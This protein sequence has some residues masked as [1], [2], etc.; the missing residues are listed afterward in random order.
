MD[1]KVRSKMLPC[2][3]AD[4]VYTRDTLVIHIS[5]FCHPSPLTETVAITTFFL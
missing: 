2:N 4:R 3:L 1:P 5:P